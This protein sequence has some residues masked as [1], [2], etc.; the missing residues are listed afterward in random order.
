MV[1]EMTLLVKGTSVYLDI[2]FNKRRN[3]K[4]KEEISEKYKKSE[5]YNK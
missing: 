1:L 3:Q 4:I 5:K 2:V